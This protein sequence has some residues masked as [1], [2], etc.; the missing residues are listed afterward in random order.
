MDKDL[1]AIQL[2]DS[3]VYHMLDHKYPEAATFFRDAVFITKAISTSNQ[4]KASHHEGSP[5]CRHHKR[6]DLQLDFI[7]LE[8][9]YQS[10]THET[11]RNLNGS[12][13]NMICKTAISICK[14]QDENFVSGR[15]ETESMS[16]ITIAASVTYNL[17]MAT[18]LWALQEGSTEKLRMA[19]YYYE[20]AYRLQEKGEITESSLNMV[21]SILN[22]VANIYL[23]LGHHGISMLFVEE[24]ITI[25]PY[26]P[27]S[28]HFMGGNNRGITWENIFRIMIGPPTAASAA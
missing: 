26:A 27:K 22:N 20:I 5:C 9:Y 7:D 23:V 6:L 21:L 13:D 17:A 16:G 25:L 4:E 12:D 19:L 18:H 8:C 10:S 11:F 14:V 2:N 28:H 1:T 15:P 3:G 24:L